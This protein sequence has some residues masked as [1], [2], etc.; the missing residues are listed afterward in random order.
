[1]R[2]GFRWLAISFEPF[3]CIK[4]KPLKFDARSLKLAELYLYPGK[5]TTRDRLTR[6]QKLKKVPIF[7]VSC[8]AFD[9]LEIRLGE[10]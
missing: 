4:C 6:G 7:V 3:A 2:I 9:C 10:V 1:M 8:S 5:Q